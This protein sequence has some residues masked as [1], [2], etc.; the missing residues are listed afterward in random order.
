MPPS[1][2][3]DAIISRRSDR[4]K[5]DAAEERFRDFA[6]IASDWLWETDADI[7]FT[8]VSQGVELS[9][10]MPDSYFLGRKI[11]ELSVPEDDPQ[12]WARHLED[13]KA[14]LLINDFSFFDI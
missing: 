14:H 3:A 6:D 2:N 5:I 10:G 9:T 13:F 4:Q 7:R 8:W 12:S 11:E 1:S